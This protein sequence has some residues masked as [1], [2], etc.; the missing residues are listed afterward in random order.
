[1]F[2]L[3]F[4]V[5]C[6]KYF[7]IKF[8]WKNGVFVVFIDFIYKYIKELQIV[9]VNKMEVVMGRFYFRVY[10]FSFIFYYGLVE[11]RWKEKFW[12]LL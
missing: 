9:N 7:V 6:F 4:Y 3:F 2:Y 11:V 10:F 5:I 8:N 1:M 12:E